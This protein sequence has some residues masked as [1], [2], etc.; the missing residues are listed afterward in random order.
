M[1]LMSNVNKA[2]RQGHNAQ[3]S[4]CIMWRGDFAGVDLRAHCAIC[5][6]TTKAAQ[7]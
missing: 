4:E 2:A 5:S 3:D 6:T 7:R 1:S